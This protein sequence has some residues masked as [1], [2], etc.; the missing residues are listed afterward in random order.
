MSSPATLSPAAAER[1]REE[2]AERSGPRRLMITDRIEK[3]RELGDLKE[4]A[5]YHA[6]KDEQGL[7]EARVRQIEAIL[8]D[9]VIVEADSTELALPGTIIEIRFAGSDDTTT[10]LLGSIE[11]RRD[12]LEV[13]STSSP[14]GTVLLNQP[15]GGPYR[16][17]TPAKRTVEV[18]IVSI[19]LAD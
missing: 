3:A 7:N 17:E 15:V 14:L 18:E 19:R 13:L 8:R 2:L 5:D 10:Y 6:A 12:D 16:Y 9:A 4:N 1:L 11:E